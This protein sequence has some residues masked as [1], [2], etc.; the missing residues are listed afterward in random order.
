MKFFAL[1]ALLGLVLTAEDSVSPTE[2]KDVKLP[3][4]VN[5]ENV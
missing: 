3:G 1:A 2:I 5:F 4:G